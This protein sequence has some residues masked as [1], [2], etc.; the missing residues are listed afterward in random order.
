M[1]ED[2]T[3]LLLLGEIYYSDVNSLTLIDSH[4][5]LAEDVLDF[6][7]KERTEDVVYF[8]HGDLVQLTAG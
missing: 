3:F 7:P 2:L 5:D 1:K 6:I 8:D 4:R